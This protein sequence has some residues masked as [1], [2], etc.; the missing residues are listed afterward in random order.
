M[1]T[2]LQLT[3]Y[4][5]SM[6]TLLKAVEIAGG[7]MA[8]ARKICAWHAER[9]LPCSVKQQHVWKWLR[10]KLPQPPA[11]YCRAIAAETGVSIHDLRPDVYGTK[12]DCAE[13]AA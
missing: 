13:S 8:L 7:Q 4:D 6:T 3:M 5:C 2:F 12:A 11:E 10:S 9:G 1:L